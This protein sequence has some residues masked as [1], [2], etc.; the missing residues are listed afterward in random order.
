MSDIR[1]KE[2]VIAKKDMD[3]INQAVI[4]LEQAEMKL[5]EAYRRKK[6]EQFNAIKQ[7]ILKLNKKISEE[8]G[9]D[10]R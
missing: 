3:F 9:N 1:K 6:P 4:S 7:F 5:E 8:L 2:N 10:Q